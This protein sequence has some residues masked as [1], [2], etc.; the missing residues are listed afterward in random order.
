MW[1]APSSLCQLAALPLLLCWLSKF[2]TSNPAIELDLGE[3]S[4]AVPAVPE[5][6]ASYWMCVGCVEW[7]GKTR[8]AQHSAAGGKALPGEEGLLHESS[9]AG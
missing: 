3:T 1:P 7:G 4:G 2:L 5:F 6:E 9:G 8:V